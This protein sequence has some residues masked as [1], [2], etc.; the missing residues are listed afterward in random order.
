MGAVGLRSI[1]VAE[2][3]DVLMG[4]TGSRRERKGSQATTTRLW[5]CTGQRGKLQKQQA[6]KLGVRGKFNN[7]N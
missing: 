3:E 4:H 2:Q 1:L 6:W 5:S 7:V